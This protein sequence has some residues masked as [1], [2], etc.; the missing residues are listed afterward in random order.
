MESINKFRKNHLKQYINSFEAKTKQ[1]SELPYNLSEH[2]EQLKNKLNVALQSQNKI[3]DQIKKLSKSIESY[4][5]KI[6][7]LEPKIAELN[8]SIVALEDELLQI[9]K[10]IADIRT[11]MSIT[12]ITLNQRKLLLEEKQQYLHQLSTLQSSI[13]WI[14]GLLFLLKRSISSLEHEIAQ[15]ETTQQLLIKELKNYEH[16]HVSL[17]IQIGNLNYNM[18]NLK[19]MHKTYASQLEHAEIKVNNLKS[20]LSHI[21]Q[22][23]E[24]TQLKSDM[25]TPYSAMQTLVNNHINYLYSLIHLS[26]KQMKLTLNI[27][28]MKLDLARLVTI[29]EA[30]YQLSNSLESTI[31]NVTLN[32]EINL[33][34][35][36]LIKNRIIKFNLT[37]GNYGTCYLDAFLLCVIEDQIRI[38]GYFP[39][40]DYIEYQQDGGVVIIFSEKLSSNITSDEIFADEGYIL[41]NR[42]DKH[43]L[44]VKIMPNKL[45]HIRKDN[46]S[47]T[48]RIL[49]ENVLFEQ[50]IID[51]VKSISSILGRLLMD[52]NL[53]I[54]E[55]TKFNQ[56]ALTK[57]RR[58]PSLVIH[59]DFKHYRDNAE[60]YMLNMF[61]YKT[62][63]YYR[64][65][66]PNISDSDSSNKIS[67]NI[68]IKQ[69]MELLQE[70]SNQSSFSISLNIPSGDR[71]AFKFISYDHLL[72]EV[73]LLNPHGYFERLNLL[74]LESY[75][76]RVR[77]FTQDL[78]IKKRFKTKLLL[79]KS[80]FSISDVITPKKNIQYVFHNDAKLLCYE[81]NPLHTYSGYYREIDAHSNIVETIFE[82]GRATTARKF[83]MS[84]LNNGHFVKQVNFPIWIK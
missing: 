3:Q 15:E 36:Q 27:E 72:E 64:S 48:V 67:C 60:I 10:H 38:N 62:I 84:N 41:E 11:R 53:N 61:N 16:K 40:D 70:L 57:K 22:E 29:S 26:S 43:K 33:L 73:I 2:S 66:R 35:Q 32:H 21:M 5:L 28:Q 76:F 12:Q 54:I 65:N 4:S 83:L 47:S 14:F 81:Q 31:D 25:I 46:S 58:R 45:K 80:Q 24:N 56:Y 74:A 79:L 42:A 59:D 75:M 52:Q 17:K 55:Y 7:E 39:I 23:I 18:K 51:W 9:T 8:H 78:K 6:V 44:Y 71:H 34:E 68:G 20:D 63:E 49:S 13:Y 82:Q 30:I 50:K 19:S 1:N 77:L 69:L 37:Q